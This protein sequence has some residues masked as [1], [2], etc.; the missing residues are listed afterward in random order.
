MIR[1]HIAYIDDSACVAKTHEAARCWLRAWKDLMLALGL[2][3]SESKIEEPTR[4]LLLLGL[5][6]NCV[7]TP[8]ISVEQARI[9]K[10]LVL[11][12]RYKKGGFFTLREAQSVMGSIAFITQVVRFGKVFNRGLAL[13]TMKFHDW[14]RARGKSS[15]GKL[16]LPI[17]TRVLVDWSILE[18]VFESFN[19]IDATAPARYE[20]APRGPAQCDASFWGAGTF[21]EGHFSSVTWEEEGIVIFDSNGK[22]LVST[23]FVEALG[24]RQLLRHNAPFWV[25]KFI[26]ICIDNT[27][28]V[29]C[30][31]GERS[32]SEQVLPILL[33]CV[34]IIVAFMIKPKFVAIRSEEMWF[35]DP[36]SRLQQPGKERLYKKM[37]KSRYDKWKRSNIPWVPTRA[38]GPVVPAALTIPDRWLE[39]RR[40]AGAC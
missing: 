20:R 24:L 37:F 35:A 23:T 15:S 13:Q 40:C 8:T 19:G 38:K 16:L 9:D 39:A 1:A 11:M 21:C 36:L 17:D 25:E 26:T 27:G 4:I 32:K 2:P 34:S 5:L 30:I 29:S 12:A 31:R 22:P 18:V 7:S 10:A 28:L 6:I 3:W 14:A 33:E